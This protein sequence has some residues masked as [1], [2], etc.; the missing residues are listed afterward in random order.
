MAV[1]DQPQ[2]VKM[3]AQAEAVKE[4]KP[5]V[6]GSFVKRKP[7]DI[8]EI[9]GWSCGVPIPEGW[10]RYPGYD[11]VIRRLKPEPP[12]GETQPAPAPAPAPEKKEESSSCEGESGHCGHGH[13]YMAVKFND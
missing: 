11:D 1:E 2:E 12:K 13:T 3:E 4:E 6:P 8:Y 7:K 10:E 9:R 5:V